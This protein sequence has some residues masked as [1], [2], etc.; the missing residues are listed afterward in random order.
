MAIILTGDT[1]GLIDIDKVTE[2]FDANDEYTKDD[3]LV[4]LGDAGILWDGAQDKEIQKILNNLPVVSYLYSG[5]E[6]LQSYLNHVA[7]NLDFE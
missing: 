2:Y 3:Y 4:I 7:D 6:A 1:H 5:E